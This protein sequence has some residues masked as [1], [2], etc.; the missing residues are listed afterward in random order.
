MIRYTALA[1]ALFLAVP[2]G[3]EAQE[4][5]PSHCISLVENTPGLE[6]VWKAG[7]TDPLP[8]HTVRLSYIDHSMYLIQTQGG[9]SAVTDY[10]GFIGT[11]DVVPDVATMNHAHSSHWTASPDPRIPNVLPGW[12]PEGGPADHHL[13]LG[14]MLVRN[15]PTDIRGRF[16]GDVEED[17]NSIFIFEVAGLCIGHLGHL[18]HEPSPEQYAAIG[19]LDVV[20]APID[21]GMTVPQPVMMDILRRVRASIVLPMHWFSYGSLNAFLAGMQDDFR[22]RQ[23][24]E[25]SLE[26]SLRSLPSEPTIIVLQPRY[27]GFDDLDR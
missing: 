18:H 23:H 1:A 2:L 6:V 26:V 5:R 20:M 16:G 21:G 12:N 8:D 22:I 7:Y 17:G 4:R 3:A 24:P 27:V 10:A 13:D 19:R 14:E 11:P 25:P 15:V 9:L